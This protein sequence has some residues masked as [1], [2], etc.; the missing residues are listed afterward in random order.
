MKSQIAWHGQPGSITKQ[1]QRGCSGFH[2]IG[3]KGMMG[4]HQ[5]VQDE[6]KPDGGREMAQYHYGNA[7]CDAC[8][9]RHSFRKSEDLEPRACSNC[10]T[11]FDYPQWEMYTSA[12][13]GIPVCIPRQ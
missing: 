10:H 9:T 12:K 8:H 7:Q 11:G 2:K 1:G 5:G 13:H 3:Q 6:I 4:I